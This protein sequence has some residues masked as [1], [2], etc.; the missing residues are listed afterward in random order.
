[1]QMSEGVVLETFNC[2]ID[3]VNNLHSDIDSLKCKINYIIMRGKGIIP[4]G[5]F[6]G[7][8]FNINKDFDGIQCETL[9]VK[10]HGCF[11]SMDCEG[12]IGEFVWCCNADMLTLRRADN[13]HFDFRAALPFLCSRLNNMTTLVHIFNM[14][15]PL[16][17]VQNCYIRYYKNDCECNAEYHERINAVIAQR[18][19]DLKFRIALCDI[20]H[21]HRYIDIPKDVLLAVIDSFWI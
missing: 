7:V 18:Q 15:L 20:E 12:E 14:P 1:M 5:S 17:P 19:S 2:I 9:L 8:C 21:N 3:H 10:A 6:E 4:K 13:N 16:E 11:V